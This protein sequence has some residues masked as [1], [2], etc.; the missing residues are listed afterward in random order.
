MVRRAAEDCG[1]GWAYWELDD[2][3]GLIADRADTG[4]FDEA[5]LGALFGAGG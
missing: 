2:G 4:N 3:F 5:M 1:I